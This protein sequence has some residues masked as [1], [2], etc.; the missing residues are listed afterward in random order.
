MQSEPVTSVQ[1]S[2]SDI[3][4][5]FAVNQPRLIAAAVLLGLGVLLAF[6]LRMISVRLV[7]AM[8]RAVPGRAFRTSFG[9]FARER[10]VSHIVG[11]VVFWAVLLFFVATAADALGVPLLSAVVASLSHFVPRVFVAILIVVAGL[12]M[13]NLAR[14]AVAATAA[15]G[16]TS[17]GAGLG[18]V[19]RVAIV[20]AAVLIAVA[21]L[22][23][24]IALLTSIFSVALAALLGG[25]ALAFGLGAR[26]AISNIIGSHYLR[27]T[28]E[29]GQTVRIGGIEGT[30]AELSATAVI[31]DV[32]EGRVIIPAKQFGEMPSS[33]L[34]KR[35]ES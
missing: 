27:Q 19:L 25:F 20:I 26:T 6:V 3:G 22:G 4:H 5:W 9:G 17:F 32:P 33:L 7:T 13:G 14:G 28:F 23:V 30:V 24:D 31:L 21:E 12:V 34:V 29:V 35:D 15:S 8:E 2:M 11:T 1:R 16:G 10:P 18:Q